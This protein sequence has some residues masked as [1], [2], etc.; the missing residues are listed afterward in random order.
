MNF[1]K[2][3][4]FIRTSCWI[5]HDVSAS[6]RGRGK[7]VVAGERPAEESVYICGVPARNDEDDRVLAPPIILP[8]NTMNERVCF[9]VS[10]FLSAPVA[11]VA[12]SRGKIN[13]LLPATHATQGFLRL[14]LHAVYPSFT[15]P[16]PHDSS[17]HSMENFAPRDKGG[18]DFVSNRLV[19]LF[20]FL[21][22]CCWRNIERQATNFTIPGD[23][24]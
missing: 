17:F 12:G 23:N 21:V 4:R 9:T 2:G 22:T 3:A 15:T 10:F 11:K 18:V 14:F 5:F 24:L 8:H 20:S 1:W 16:P 7:S 13:L 19:F 6:K